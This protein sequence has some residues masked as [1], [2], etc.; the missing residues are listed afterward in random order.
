MHGYVG[1]TAGGAHFD[2]RRV[3]EV[4]TRQRVDLALAERLEADAAARTRR[5]MRPRS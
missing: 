5:I 1:I 4:A 2:A 3:E